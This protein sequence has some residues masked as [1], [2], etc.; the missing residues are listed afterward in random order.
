D[1]APDGDAPS[2]PV[3]ADAQVA[4][5]LRTAAARAGD[6]ALAQ[7]L[8]IAAAGGAGDAGLRVAAAKRW[9]AVDPDNLVPRLFQGLSADALLAAAR[10]ATDADTHMY[11]G[12]RWMRSALAKHPPTDEEQRA[13]TG[14]EPFR[15]EEAAA[16]AA[17]AYWA[18]AAMPAYHDLVQACRG[19]ALRTSPA[20]HADC[21]HAADLLAEHSDSALGVQVGLAMLHELAVGGAERAAIEERRRR[22]DWRMQQWGR[23]AAQQPRDGAAQFARLLDDASVGSE[24]QLVARV[25]AEGGVLPD[26]PAGWRPPRR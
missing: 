9:Q 12:V 24:L 22:M 25:L 23:L 15:R 13:L 16:M 18:G 11:A 19:T 21:R 7:Q 3:P 1:G 14:G 5:W 20:R 17:M 8:V 4:T 6:D 2:R 10:Q 26:P